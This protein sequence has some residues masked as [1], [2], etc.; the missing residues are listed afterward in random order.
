[1]IQIN[2]DWVTLPQRTDQTWFTEILCQLNY[3]DLNQ[4]SQLFQRMSDRDEIRTIVFSVSKERSVFTLDNPAHQR[5]VMSV[6]LPILKELAVATQFE[7][8][9]IAGEWQFFFNALIQAGFQQKVVHIDLS[10]EAIQGETE[11]AGFWQELASREAPV[12]LKG[13]RVRN[14]AQRWTSVA[15]LKD[16]LYATVHVQHLTLTCSETHVQA[17]VCERCNDLL[18]LMCLEGY[19]GLGHPEVCLENMAVSAQ[20]LIPFLVQQRNMRK[21]TFDTTKLAPLHPNEAEPNFVSSAWDYVLHAL[22]KCGALREFVMD[23][24][25]ELLIMDYGSRSWISSI[26]NVSLHRAS[27]EM[28]KGLHLRGGKVLS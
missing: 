15:C 21:I 23:D 18:E 5:D 2:R 22:A 8:I 16:M 17:C 26:A 14:D 12:F 9:H 1:M 20:L 6:F 4:L 11:K 13:I 19:H 24:M 28:A 27:Q 7:T 10:T 25:Y 3:G